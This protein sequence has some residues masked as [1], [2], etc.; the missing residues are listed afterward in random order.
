MDE[1]YGQASKRLC[2][3]LSVSSGSARCTLTTI[4]ARQFCRQT[5][6]AQ[7]AVVR[8]ATCRRSW[9]AALCLQICSGG[10]RSCRAL[11]IA[12]R[13]SLLSSGDGGT[14]CKHREP[15][16]ESLN[17]DPALWI[18]VP[19]SSSANG[20]QPRGRCPPP[21]AEQHQP[22]RTSPSVRRVAFGAMKAI[23]FVT[24]QRRRKP[25]LT[26]GER[27]ALEKHARRRQGGQCVPPRSTPTGFRRS[28]TSGGDPARL[29]PKEELV[30][31]G[32]ETRG[33][34]GI[35]RAFSAPS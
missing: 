33:T 32:E 8:G 12:S 16:H 27:G 6:G 1:L 29:P 18:N 31:P 24:G 17:L 9:A 21:E 10:S 26:K 25:R 13:P 7:N 15:S 30:E 14:R 3:G 4:R 5:I 28:T 22:T 19:R 2:S 35:D 11:V 34:K 23:T 20:E